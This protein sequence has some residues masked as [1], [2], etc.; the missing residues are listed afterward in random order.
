MGCNLIS[1]FLGLPHTILRKI[2]RKLRTEDE[3]ISSWKGSFEQPMI[4]ICCITYNHEPYIEDALEGFLMQ[5][6]EF[7]FEILIH[8]DASTDSTANII[9]K[10]EKK[11]PRLIKPIYQSENQYSKGKKMNLAFNFPRAKGEYIALCEGDDYW[12]EPKKLQDQVRKM[13]EFPDINI[14]FH[15]A[16]KVDVHELNKNIKFSDYGGA[17]KIFT[18]KE[19]ISGGG[20]FMPTASIVFKRNIIEK[21]EINRWF[22]KSLVGDFVIQVFSSLESGALFIPTINSIYRQNVFGSW[23]SSHRSS[24]SLIKT[25]KLLTS[26]LF[27]LACDLKQYRKLILMLALKQNFIASLMLLKRMDFLCFIKHLPLLWQSFYKYL[28]MK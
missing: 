4:S 26:F 13:R 3:I 21:K 22:E 2:M 18:V 6:V 16:Y 20:G 25:R 11:Y 12:I 7:P 1:G 10:Y 24:K 9:R 19:V 15:P 8:D 23:S 28:G 27:W 17:V 5:E 14:S